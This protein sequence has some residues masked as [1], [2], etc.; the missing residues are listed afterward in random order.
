MN[1]RLRDWNMEDVTDLVTCINNKKISD[2]LSDGVPH[3][4]TIKDAEIFIKSNLCADRKKQLSKAITM[5]N[6]LI[7]SIGVFAKED[8]YR[9]T[10]EMGYWL[11]EPYWGKGIMSKAISMICKEAFDTLDIIRI[12]A[13]PF[14]YN[15]ASQRALEKAG[16]SFEGILKSNVIKNNVVYDSHMYALLKQ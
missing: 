14:D 3:P 16:F 4:Y 1:I 11:A 5:N 9:K 13:E 7:G 12:F 6:Q 2:N 10:A 15:K 8:I